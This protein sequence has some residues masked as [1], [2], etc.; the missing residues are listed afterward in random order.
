MASLDFSDILFV[1]GKKQT[2]RRLAMYQVN[3]LDFSGQSIYVGLDVHKKSWTVSIFSEQCE[4]KTFTQPPKVDKLVHYLKRNFPGAIYHAVYEAG[5]SGFWACDQ[6]R[7][8]GVNC[9]VTN[10]ADVP[11]TN[12]ER[13]GKRDSIDSRKLTRSLRNGDLKGIYVPARSKL[14]DR[15]LVRTRQSMVRKQTRCK[16]QIKSLLYF[17]GIDLPEEVVARSWSQKF[18]RWLDG[19]RMERASGDLALKAHLNELHHL[20]QT[21]ASL[22]RAIILLSREPEY[23][24]MVQLLRTVPGISTLAAMIFLTE[25]C[26]LARFASLDKLAS[27]VGLIPDVEA[28]GETEHIKNLTYR[29]NPQLR[30]VLIEAAWVAA[31]KDPVLLLAFNKYCQR[32]KKTRAIV[33]IARKLLNRIRYVLKNQAEYVPAVVQ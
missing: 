27:Y 15:S 14:E 26:E 6:L 9:I 8:Q 33:K 17:Y 32:M 11:T 4:H 31:R 19:L 3:K 29:R 2:E 24:H 18:F 10:P 21:I 1:E 13:T 30:A 20:R 16:N 23:R 7:E 5:F 22:N 25:L 28:S 12:K